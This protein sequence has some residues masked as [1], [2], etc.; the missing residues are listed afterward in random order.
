MYIITPQEINLNILITDLHE[1][2]PPQKFE[3]V[4]TISDMQL[5]DL[6]S[7]PYGTKFVINVIDSAIGCRF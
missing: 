6:N 1:I 5:A 2:H 4:D 3:R 7:K